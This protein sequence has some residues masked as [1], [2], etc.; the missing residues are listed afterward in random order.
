MEEK[1]KLKL[2]WD[3]I[4]H[5]SDWQK[6][7]YLITLSIDEAMEKQEHSISVA[8]TQNGTSSIEGNLRNCYN[9]L[10]WSFSA[11][12]KVTQ[13]HES[14]DHIFP[15]EEWVFHLVEYKTTLGLHLTF[16]VGQVI[17][18]HAS[19]KFEYMCFLSATSHT[20][21]LEVR[22]KP[23]LYWRQERGP[24]AKPE[25]TWDQFWTELLL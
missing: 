21:P 1:C 2:H 22:T 7:K 25:L 17:F 3:T 5:L 23:P 4:S 14:I 19:K 16:Q 13:R 15:W 18:E 11:F 20:P 9:H 8:R 10:F 24:T 12:K 6:S